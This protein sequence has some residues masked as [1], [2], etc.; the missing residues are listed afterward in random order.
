[1]RVSR[2]GGEERVAGS[3]V[4]F[5][6]LLRINWLAFKQA[7]LVFVVSLGSALFIIYFVLEFMPSLM[8]LSG[9]V[10]VVASALIEE[11]YS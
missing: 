9:C 3:L 11:L 1:M 4:L 8:N 10:R 6:T 5:G 7:G 2:S